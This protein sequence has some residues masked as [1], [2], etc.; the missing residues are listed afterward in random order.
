VICPVSGPLQK[1]GGDAT[2]RAV[3]GAALDEGRGGSPTDLPGRVEPSGGGGD[4][5]DIGANV[6]AIATKQGAPMAFSTDGWTRSRRA[7]RRWTKWR[8]CRNCSTPAI[9]ISRPTVQEERQ[10]GNDN[11]ARYKGRVLQIPADRHRRH[12]VEASVRVDEYPDSRLAVF[13]GPRRLARYS[14]AGTL[15]GEPSRQAA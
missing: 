5:G 6:P 8:V 13:H 2:D 10:V 4:F 7:G 11:T 15:L 1:G 14:A 12:Y 3:T 9:S